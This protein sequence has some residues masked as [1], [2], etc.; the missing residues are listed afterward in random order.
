MTGVLKRL[1]QLVIVVL[2]VTLFTS[3]LIRIIPGDVTAVIIPFD[4]AFAAR[5]VR[6]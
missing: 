4:G 6:R 5:M 2:L 1:G 3:M